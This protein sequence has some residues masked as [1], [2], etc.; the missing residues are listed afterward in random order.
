V[1]PVWSRTPAAIAMAAT[2]LS[3]ASSGRFAPGLGAG[4]PPLQRAEVRPL[5][6]G[7]LPKKPVPIMLAALSPGSVRMA[8]ELADRWPCGVRQRA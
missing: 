7:V 5:R 3:R 6:L 1:L 8:G 4:S 2:S